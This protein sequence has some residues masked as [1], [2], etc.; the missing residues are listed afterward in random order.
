MDNKQKLGYILLGA[1]IMAVGITIGQFITPNIE[2]QS[3]GVFDTITCH[4]ILVVDKKGEKGITLDAT[5]TMNSLLVF[6][7][8]NNK[9]GMLLFGA[10]SYAGI[11]LRDS[12]AGK[13]AISLITSDVGNAV[14]VSDRQRGESA[15]VLKSSEKGNSIG[16]NGQ[17]GRLAVT[18]LAGNE[19]KNGIHIYNPRGKLAIRLKS[20][21]DFNGV[22][23]YDQKQEAAA[24]LYARRGQE[25]GN[26]VFVIDKTRELTTLGD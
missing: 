11:Q 8:L 1:G 22:N 20:D 12:R 26:G 15:I 3:N 24:G 10:D 21:E 14:T 5:G 19:W 18:I 6:N 2:A 17:N 13:D 25:V 4:K 7:K 23:L 16:V 9:G